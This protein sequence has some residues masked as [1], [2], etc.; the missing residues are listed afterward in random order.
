MIPDSWRLRGTAAPAL[1]RGFLVAIP[2]G[3]AV[4][5]DIEL[6][7]PAAAAVTIG[8]SITG[9]VAFDAPARTRFNWQLAIAPL[10]GA[11]GALG[12]LTGA[13]PVVAVVT[14][15]VFASVAAL[16]VAVSRR[17][18]I[19]ALNCVLALLIGQGLASA[20]A[21]PPQVLVLGGAGAL[22]Q[23]AL[24][25][26]VALTQG[27]LERPRLISG[28][29]DAARQ[30]RAA[31][32]LDSPSLRHAIRSGIALGSAVAVYHLVGL[33]RHGYWVPLTVL[34]VLKAGRAETNERIA[35][36]AAGT[37]AGLAVATGLAVLVGEGVVANTAI[38]VVSAAC[39]YAMLTLEYALFTF[40]ITIYIVTLSHALG[41]SAVE[42]VDERGLATALGIVIVLL[43]FVVW[44]DRAPLPVQA[45]T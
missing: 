5:V 6:R 39:A 13:S 16:S 1:R 19:A 15:A 25:L 30:V 36:R 33:G 23:A 37:L 10:I 32:G 34:F 7:S 20:A 14:M 38:L 21:D 9:F 2:V 29:R 12:A 3:I 31:L 17:L 4:V 27:P 41:E 35:M 11:S 24:S 43:A 45:P 26:V 8:A 42:A 18:A 28:A 22:A 44:R 40:A